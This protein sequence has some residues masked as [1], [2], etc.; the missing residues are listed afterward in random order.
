MYGDYYHHNHTPYLYETQLQH[1]LQPE[2]VEMRTFS[3]Q[4]IVRHNASVGWQQWVTL[5]GIVYD[6]TGFRDHF[7]AYIQ[8]KKDDQAKEKQLKED[9]ALRLDIIKNTVSVGEKTFNERYGHGESIET[10]REIEVEIGPFKIGTIEKV[11]SW[12]FWESVRADVITLHDELTKE[13]DKGETS[14]YQREYLAQLRR[15][16]RKYRDIDPLQRW[17]TGDSNHTV[18]LLPE[19]PSTLR[20]WTQ[21]WEPLDT[22]LPESGAWTC[23]EFQLPP[24]GDTH[25]VFVA[26]LRS[27]FSDD[28]Q[29]QFEIS[30]DVAWRVL[31]QHVVRDEQMTQ[32]QKAVQMSRD[33]RGKNL[34][35]P[36]RV[37]RRRNQLAKYFMD[38]YH[39]SQERMADFL[40]G[41]PL[42]E[43]TWERMWDHVSKIHPEG[44]AMTRKIR[45]QASLPQVS[46]LE[47]MKLNWHELV[48]V[49]VGQI[50]DYKLT[51]K[52]HIITG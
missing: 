38:K 14:E 31:P 15:W 5:K 39:I 1:R 48:K 23:A 9:V 43:R 51:D 10:W 32:K 27:H 16:L 24:L 4:E 13:E 7:L 8:K 2:L 41:I 22:E 26:V 34:W 33:R 20:E 46:G 29:F 28:I 21:G 42:D 52:K 11:P 6:A 44:A 12:K 49:K 3:R 40:H 19:D 25:Q 36:D 30:G 47:Y 45:N 50:V 35:D 18:F 37:N 17:P